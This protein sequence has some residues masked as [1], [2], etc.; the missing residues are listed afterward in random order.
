M[1]AGGLH[2]TPSSLFH[3]MPYNQERIMQACEKALQEA[4]QAQREA[5]WAMSLEAATQVYPEND[6]RDGTPNS[7]RLNIV[8]AAI[9]ALPCPP[10]VP[11]E[12]K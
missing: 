9:R 12:S 2:S 6:W 3:Y 4:M 5:T 10:V 1:G 11:T 8:Y 7:K